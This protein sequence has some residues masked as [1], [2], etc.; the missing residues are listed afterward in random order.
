MKSQKGG[1]DLDFDVR[2]V[3][4]V[5]EL[6]NYFAI[7]HGKEFHSRVRAH[8]G[9]DHLDPGLHLFRGCNHSPATEEMLA[10]ILQ[11]ISPICN[12]IISDGTLKISFDNPK[13]QPNCRMI[14]VPGK[15][16]MK[17]EGVTATPTAGIALGL[18]SVVISVWSRGGITRKYMSV[19][20]AA[21]K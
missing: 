15:S 14:K 1:I 13:A 18:D 3:L 2:A 21:E 5:A 19:L 16:P 12:T 4:D 10:W 7:G 6:E 9:C 8:D 11:K 20:D 17:L